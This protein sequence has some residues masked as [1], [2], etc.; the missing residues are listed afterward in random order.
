MIEIREDPGQGCCLV[1]SE[2]YD[3]QGYPWNY[4][5]YINLDPVQIDV[6]AG[7]LERTPEDV[8]GAVLAHEKGHLEVYYKVHRYLNE[9]EN[10][11]LAW[12]YAEKIY[13]G[14]PEVLKEVRAYALASYM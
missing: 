8:K 2:S 14:P 6:I 4:P 5:D 1:F 12:E 13:K 7:V 10:E 3:S 9:Q 11:L